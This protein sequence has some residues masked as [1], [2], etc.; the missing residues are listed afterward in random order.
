MS[1]IIYFLKWNFSL[2]LTGFL[3]MADSLVE[4]VLAHFHILVDGLV[5]FLSLQVDL[6]CEL[7]VIDRDLLDYQIDNQGEDSKAP[8]CDRHTFRQVRGS[9]DGRS[10]TP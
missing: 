5:L 8:T 4:L 1:F 10:E 9:N 6:V 2:A 7:E 3:Y